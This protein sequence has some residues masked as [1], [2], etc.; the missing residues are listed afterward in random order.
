MKEYKVVV[1]QESAL[2]SLILG[3]AIANEVKFSEFLNKHAQEGWRVVTME[4]D[5]RRLFLFWT[6]E[7][8]LIVMERERS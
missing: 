6:R 1:F 8:Y 7:A 5:L 3:S 2:S 4:K